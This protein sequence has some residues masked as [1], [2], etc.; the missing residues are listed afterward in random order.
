MLNPEE[1]LNAAEVLFREEYL[2]DAV[3]RA[4]HA[5]FYIAEALLNEK[6]LRYST[7]GTVHGAFAQYYVKP[8]LFDE[9]YHKLLTG[10]FRRRMLGD[11][12]EVVQFRSE[13]V[14][15][16]ITEAWGFLEAAKDYLASKI[17]LVIP[18]GQENR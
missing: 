6:D 15:Q 8:K 14:K 13:E 4:Y 17:S 2:R 16:T 11:Y 3:N 7:H 18:L 5:V 1:S 12:D 10:S 9:K